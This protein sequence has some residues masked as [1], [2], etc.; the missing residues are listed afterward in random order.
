MEQTT[1]L[2]LTIKEMGKRIAELRQIEG[3]TTAEMAAKAGVDEAEYIACEAGER[4]LN[5]AF[6]YRCALA[7][8][9]DVTDIIEGSSPTLTSYDLTRAGDGQKIEKAHGMTYYNMAAA[10]K[11]RI[12][13]PLYVRAEYSPEAERSEIPLTSHEGQELD[14]VISGKLKVQVGASY[15]ILGPGDTIYYDSSTPHGMVAVGGDCEFYAM[16]LNPAKYIAKQE[17][18]DY[19]TIVADKKDDVRRVY[20]DFIDTVEGGRQSAGSYL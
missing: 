11:N 12:A 6:L 13:D 9:V 8:G 2:A 18:E 4:D 14:L 17:K 16:V 15:E 7:F 1:G 5:F 19:A 3:F 10:Y 20:E